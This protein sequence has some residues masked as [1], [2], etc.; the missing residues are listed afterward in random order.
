[1]PVQ[2][3]EHSGSVGI[4]VPEPSSGAEGG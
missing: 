2:L 3:T 4:T 1:V